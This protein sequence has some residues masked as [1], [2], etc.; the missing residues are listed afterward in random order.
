MI[1]YRYPFLYEWG[2]KVQYTLN[3]TF[4]QTSFPAKCTSAGVR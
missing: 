2:C 4:G 3:I 1:C